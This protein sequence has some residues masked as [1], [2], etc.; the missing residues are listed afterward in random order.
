MIEKRICGTC[1][2][3]RPDPFDKDEW[4]CDNERSDYY[5]LETGYDDTCEEHEPRISQILFGSLA[6]ICTILISGLANYFID[7]IY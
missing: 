5:C 1:A 7:G 2:H 3:H 4:I 6:L